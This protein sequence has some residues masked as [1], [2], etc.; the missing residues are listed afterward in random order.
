LIWCSKNQINLG[1]LD[2]ANNE[3]GFTL[4]RAPDNAGAPGTFAPIAT[5]AANVT[6]YRDTA[7]TAHTR[8]WYRVSAT[9]PWG[10]S[11]R[12]NTCPA[13]TPAN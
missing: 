7:R 11:A 5:L 8:Y 4:E 13:T 3:T 2:N 10:N 9:S 6:G 12:S 1:W